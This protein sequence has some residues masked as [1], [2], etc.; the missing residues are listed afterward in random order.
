MPNE[1]D[2]KRPLLAWHLYTGKPYPTPPDLVIPQSSSSHGDQLQTAMCKEINSS[3]T[4]D[5]DDYKGIKTAT[6]SFR[7]TCHRVGKCHQFTSMECAAKFGGAINDLLHWRVDLTHPD[8]NV[9]LNVIED[10][11]KVSVALTSV[12]LHKRNIIQFGPTSLR[13][14]IAYNML[15]YASRHLKL[16]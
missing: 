8:I 12:S 14:T 13:S 1:L 2:W 7:V 5:I 16:L 9:I 10:S 6:P 4:I 15:R 11:I 3:N